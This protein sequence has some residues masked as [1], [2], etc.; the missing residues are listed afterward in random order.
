MENILSGKTTFAAQ[1][2]L[3]HSWLANV[4]VQNAKMGLWYVL[5]LSE[6]VQKPFMRSVLCSEDTFLWK[7]WN[8]LFS[9]V[10]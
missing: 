10:L 8:K 3:K 2:E 1:L 5:E 9:Q 7:G 4:S 6:I